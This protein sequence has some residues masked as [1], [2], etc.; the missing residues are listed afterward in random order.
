MGR[1]YPF[2][3]AYDVRARVPDELD[4]ART[5][6]IGRAYVEVVQAATVV[7]G[8]DMR[9]SSPMLAAALIGGITA[10]GADVLDIGL[11]GTGGGY[12]PTFVQ[13]ADGRIRVTGKRTP[14][15]PTRLA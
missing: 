3:R 14:R 4:A 11:C 6:R 2:F 1:L 9:L 12:L 15:H 10:A 5:R 7:V 8:H 13:H